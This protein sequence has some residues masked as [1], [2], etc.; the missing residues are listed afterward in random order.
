LP[1][2][3]RH[4]WLCGARPLRRR[5]AHE[6]VLELVH[7]R[8]GEQQRLVAVRHDRGAGNEGMASFEEEVDETLSD[9]TGGQHVVRT[10]GQVVLLV[11]SVVNAK[12]S[13]LDKRCSLRFDHDRLHP[14]ASRSPAT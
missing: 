4:F 1:L 5:Q 3:R 13:L 10:S 2:T 7:S 8:V 9:F 6:D 12:S 11:Q 14:A